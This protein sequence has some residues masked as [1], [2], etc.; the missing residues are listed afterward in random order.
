M[1]SVKYQLALNDVYGLR[2]PGSLSQYTQTQSYIHMLTD[3][4]DPEKQIEFRVK[5]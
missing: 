4:L 5:L 3:M 2:T 1:F